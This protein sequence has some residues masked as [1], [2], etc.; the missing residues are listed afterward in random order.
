MNAPFLQSLGGLHVPV[1]HAMH[2]PVGLQTM[3][4]PQTVPGFLFVVSVH[5][6]APEEQTNDPFLH[7]F[8]GVQVP[9]AHAM[10]VPVGLQTMPVPQGV[11]PALFVLSTHAWEPVAHENVPF[12]HMLVGWQA[13]LIVHVPQVPAPSHTMLVPHAV[14]GP[15]LV[16]SVHTGAPVAQDMVPFLQPFEGWHVPVAQATHVAA[17]VQT[18]PIPQAVPVGLF[19][20]SMHSCDPVSHENV[21]FLQRLP[22]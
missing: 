4:V 5:T 14:P 1:A 7:G 22:G 20:V 2:V 16:L 11:P 9:V 12:L 19:V 13:M 3:P 6:W 15:L 21:P 10:H 17:L 8:V 18:I